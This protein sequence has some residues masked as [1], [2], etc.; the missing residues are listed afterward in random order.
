M[1]ELPIITSIVRNGQ[2]YLPLLVLLSEMELNPNFFQHLVIAGVLL[3]HSEHGWR[4]D[5]TGHPNPSPSAPLPQPTSDIMFSGKR[6]LI[7]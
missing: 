1:D 6:G 7:L 4:E 5:D 3:C 2:N